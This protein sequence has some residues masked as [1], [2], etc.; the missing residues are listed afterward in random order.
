MAEKTYL[1]IDT[2]TKIRLGFYKDIT[3][4]VDIAVV[5]WFK[6]EGDIIG[7]IEDPDTGN[8]TGDP[9]LRINSAKGKKVIE[10][11][12]DEIGAR[13]SKILIPAG[14]IV[15]IDIREEPFRPAELE[16]VRKTS[17]QESKDKSIVSPKEPDSISGNE[18]TKAAK[19]RA[20]N[21]N[22]IRISPLA[23][24]V[25]EEHGIS[26]EDVISSM[27]NG[28]TEVTKEDVEAYQRSPIKSG[29]DK[30]DA[31]EL[32]ASPY[33]KGKIK[34][35]EKEGVLTVQNII[36]TGP[37]AVIRMADVD[38]AVMQAKEEKSDIVVSKTDSVSMSED[39]LYAPIIEEPSVRRLTIARSQQRA[40]SNRYDVGRGINIPMASGGRDIDVTNLIALREKLKHSFAEE[41]GIKLRY[42][43]FFLAAAAKL[44]RRKELSSL[45]S[46]WEWLENKRG[47]I[48]R[49]CH[50][51]LA[52]AVD[53][54]EG[55]LVPVIRRCE[56][57][58]FVAIA[59]ETEEILVDVQNNTLQLE[60][61]EGRTFT[62]N[63]TGALGVEYPHPVVPEGNAAII[64][65]GRIRKNGLMYVE[66][67]FDHRPFDAGPPERFMTELKKILEECPEQLLYM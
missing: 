49:F 29:T 40:W 67:A 42:D 43:H 5:E 62:V 58:S 44:L 33:V 66:I 27:Q 23:R 14:E 55:L 60:R 3:D 54:P 61:M 50:I 16:L 25:A 30:R 9:I 2:Q 6:K 31:L 64:A 51:N 21:T 15:T 38:R 52:L 7:A 37:D 1:D 19:N 12:G 22:A 47:Q 17:V 8:I 45:N 4:V 63:N 18:K 28:A 26:L 24:A 46:C 36:P 53:H 32:N 57:K 13:I 35:L 10:G 39:A 11:I 20:E 56:E 34:A 41:H 59:K 65:F 48:V